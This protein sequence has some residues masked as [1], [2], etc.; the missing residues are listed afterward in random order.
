MKY[1]TTTDYYLNVIEKFHN[2]FIFIL[3]DYFKE[4]ENYD[5]VKLKLTKYYIEQPFAEHKP[6]DSGYFEYEKN[7]YLIPFLSSL[8][9]EK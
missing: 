8:E 5:N 2:N 6:L 1:N 7:R 4:I 3:L 9:N